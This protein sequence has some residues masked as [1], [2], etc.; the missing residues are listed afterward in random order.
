MP[1]F[2]TSATVAGP[3]ISPL[4]IG[5]RLLIGLI[6]GRVV[7]LV[8]NWTRL[9]TERTPSFPA[10]LVLLCILIAVVTQVIGESVARAFS[11]VGALSIVRFRTVVQDTRDTAFVIFAVIEGMA[12]G[13]GYL[14]VALAGFGVVA[15][16]A[17]L[18]RPRPAGS[19]DLRVRVGVGLNP[20]ELLSE[21][22]QKHFEAA[23]VVTAGT[24][25]QGAALDLT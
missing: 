20:S 22:L 24:G 9:P 23:E 8:Y 5:I 11:L 19:W 14:P 21:V 2:L 10:T 25:R 3:A 17:V 7:A 6:L 16:A 15:L 13:G 18:V 4:Q 12:A 1:E